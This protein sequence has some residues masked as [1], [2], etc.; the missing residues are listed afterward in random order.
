MKKI[1]AIISVFLIFIVNVDAQQNMI[2]VN[3]RGPVYNDMEISIE[4]PVNSSNYGYVTR[5]SF[6]TDVAISY[7]EYYFDR[8]DNTS[9]IIMGVRYHLVD[10]TTYT[11]SILG[12]WGSYETFE[13]SSACSYLR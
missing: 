11:P 2:N 10:G 7:K 12:Y 6:T 4:C 8:G 5:G 1:L 13:S 9:S 3:P